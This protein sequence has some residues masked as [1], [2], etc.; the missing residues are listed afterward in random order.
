M[1]F[2]FFF[3]EPAVLV[4]LW[5]PATDGRVDGQTSRDSEENRETGQD[6]LV[7]HLV[8]DN[9]SAPIQR[10]SAPLTEEKILHLTLAIY[11]GVHKCEVG[12]SC[13]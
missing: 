4:G 1:F 6:R 7:V 13:F 2:F 9:E 3:H 5:A 8:D 12:I 10:R 11:A